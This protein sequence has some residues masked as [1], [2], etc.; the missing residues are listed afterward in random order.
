MKANVSELLMASSYSSSL[1]IDVKIF[2][3]FI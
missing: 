2:G 3:K 1:R